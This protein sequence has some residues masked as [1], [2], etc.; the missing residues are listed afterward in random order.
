MQQNSS[1]LPNNR[2]TS[3]LTM[4]TP[5][6][7][8]GKSITDALAT[9]LLVIIC[10]YLPR[11]DLINFRLANKVCA[12][13]TSKNLVQDLH[14]IFTEK[15]LSNL[16]NISKQPNLSRNVRSI[17]Y[18]PYTLRALC[19]NE[20]V[21][22]IDKKLN[23]MRPDA[24][25][26]D[27]DL[28]KGWKLYNQIRKRELYLNT[29]NYDISV[30]AQA[31]PKFSTLNTIVVDDAGLPSDRVI[32]SYNRKAHLCK[33]M[34][35]SGSSGS[36]TAYKPGMS[37]ELLLAAS[38]AGAPLTTF[39]ATA[40]PLAF[41]NAMPMRSDYV[42]LSAL[43]NVKHIDIT[44]N[45]NEEEWQAG[46]NVVV[47]RLAQFL[48]LA[49]NLETLRIDLGN[50]KTRSMVPIP[51]DVV[52]GCTGSFPKLR[53]LNLRHFSC[54]EVFFSEFL[55]KHAERLEHL[56]LDTMTMADT[57][58]GWGSVFNTLETN[59]RLKS[60]QF[61]GLWYEGQDD[62]EDIACP[63]KLSASYPGTLSSSL[64]K[65]LQHRVVK[66]CMPVRGIYMTMEEIWEAATRESK[67]RGYE[68]PSD[69]DSDD[70]DDSGFYDDDD[71]DDGYF[72]DDDEEDDDDDDSVEVSDDDEDSEDSDDD[73]DD[74]GSVDD[75]EDDSSDGGDEVSDD[76]DDDDENSID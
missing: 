19:E 12:E 71:D 5:T 14:V 22:H 54:T 27:E 73:E 58:P 65:V 35:S 61:T 42:A 32:N 76:D 59:L 13:V 25:E 30:F 68:T 52:I 55:Q 3:F 48:S 11:E 47:P 40:L 34:F 1:L 29:L 46:V 66:K 17:L 51:L 18:E 20:Y 72:D 43:Q 60:S 67:K 23:L 21:Y 57:C 8:T 64:G 37:H 53:S 24:E 70:S 28:N 50:H 45:V 69:D 41:F 10:E 49:S 38:L 4:S 56:A 31:V 7:Y 63:I 62:D 9:E 74:E 75:E 26:E 33:K 6:L 16:L 15:S 44:I 2:S 36:Y 39:R